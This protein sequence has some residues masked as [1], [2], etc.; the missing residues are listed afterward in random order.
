MNGS[1][2]TAPLTVA[3][4]GATGFLGR[5][6]VAALAAAGCRLRLLARRE[7]LALGLDPSIR[8]DVVLGALEDEGAL[9]RL[10]DGAD[11]V[12][13][14]AGAIKAADDAGY[15]RVNRDGTRALAQAVQA[16]APA[17]HVVLVSSL[18]ARHPEL[19][20]YAASKRAGE[21]ALFEVLGRERTSVVRPPAIYGPGDRETMVFFELAARKLVPVPGKAGARISLLH[22]AD[23]ARMLTARVLGTPTGRVH[24]LADDRP[25]GYGWREILAAAAAAVGNR[26][27]T[28]FPLPAG[29]LQTL[30]NGAGA[31]AR[32]AGKNGMVSA[33]K[34][35]E[36]LHENWAVAPDELLRDLG[37]SPRHGLVD[38]FA[39]TAAWY[40]EAGW[41]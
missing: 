2:D 37:A 8:P 6:T 40:R 14:M 19:S 29:L 5:H 35:R 27:P 9:R 10:V 7:P 31:I 1:A 15:L 16:V 24:A 28:Y 41:L 4:T 32:I 38:G 34:I 36:L 21:D 17:A 11:V 39:A 18:A 26:S 3:V 30:G 22:G 13:H 12:L 20:G 33:G 23:A 25:E